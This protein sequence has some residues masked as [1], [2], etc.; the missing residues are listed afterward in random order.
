MMASGRGS[1]SAPASIMSWAP[2]S[3]S[4]VW[5]RNTIVPGISSRWFAINRAVV[6]RQAMWLSWPQA[7]MTP[8]FSEANGSPVS[9]WTGS[10][11]MSERMQRVLP[12]FPPFSTPM[13]P[14]GRHLR[15]S[16]PRDFSSSSIFCA[17]RNSCVPTSGCAWKSRRS[18]IR[19]G[20]SS[21]ISFLRSILVPPW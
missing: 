16:M 10:A 2:A 6:S 1:S 13:T 4:F 20:V 3:S 14:V 18:A 19:F 11:S 17:V 15:T 12:G 5:N 7:C 9:S 21:A 8:G